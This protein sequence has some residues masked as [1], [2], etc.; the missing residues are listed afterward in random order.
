ML[1]AA[2]AGEVDGVVRLAYD[3]TELPVTAA[4][5]VTAQVTTRDIDRGDSPH[6]LL[7]EIQQAPGSFAK[8]LRGKIAR[9]RRRAVGRRRRADAAAR[10]RSPTGDGRD[11]AR[12]G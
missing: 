7:K 11:R 5:V 3:G 6:F 9:R 2:Q 1:D 12:C 8:T 10:R 4:D